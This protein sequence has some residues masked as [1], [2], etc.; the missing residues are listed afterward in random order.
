MK[1]EIE[2]ENGRETRV[3][4]N[5]FSEINSF[6]FFEDPV[7]AAAYENHFKVL[8]GKATFIK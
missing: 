5:T 2:T 8:W 1:Y 6:H 7:I 4:K 3:I